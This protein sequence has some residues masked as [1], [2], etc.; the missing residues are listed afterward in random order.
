MIN[1]KD[2]E[3]VPTIELI[4]LI[5]MKNDSSQ[6]DTAQN[7]FRAFYFRFFDLVAKKAFI[8]SKRN[9]YDKD[10][11][12]EIT[13]KTFEKYWKYPAFKIEKMK[14]SNPDK[15]VELYL[16][17][18]SQHCFYDLMNERNGINVSPYDGT[19]EIVYDFEIPDEYLELNNERYKIINK[20]LSTFSNKHRIIYLTY[21]QY[22]QAG[23][24]LPRKLLAELREKL[25]IT[26]DTIRYYRYEVLSK[27]EEYTELWQKK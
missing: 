24:K 25:N 4:E 5:K 9:G 15:G 16:Y 13:E 2:Y 21:L 8:I 17:R 6:L 22:E 3:H 26:Q 18:I 20:A 19:E 27:I 11:A 10:F 14:A 12:L 7:A 23:Y 1:W